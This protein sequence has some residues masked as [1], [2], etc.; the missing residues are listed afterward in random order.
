MFFLFCDSNVISIGGVNK[1]SYVEAVLFTFNRLCEECLVGGLSLGQSQALS[2][3][4]HW[5]ETPQWVF[6]E[7]FVSA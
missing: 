5:K 1:G 2:Q 4:L 6:P 7:G 3:R